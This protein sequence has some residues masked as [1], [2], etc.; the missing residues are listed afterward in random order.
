MYYVLN[1]YTSPHILDMELLYDGIES[2]Y[3]LAPFTMQNKV[4]NHAYLY[5]LRTF[6]ELIKLKSVWDYDKLLAV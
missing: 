3:I 5:I 2:V 4:F 1:D 6:Y